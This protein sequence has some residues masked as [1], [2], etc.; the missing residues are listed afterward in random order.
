[1]IILIFNIF[2]DC[3]IDHRIFSA[4]FESEDNIETGHSF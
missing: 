3:I 1:M 2:R 4:D